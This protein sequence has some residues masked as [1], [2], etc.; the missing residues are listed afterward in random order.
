MVD[1]FYKNSAF[2]PPVRIV[3]VGQV[4]FH[5]SDPYDTMFD[6]AGGALVEGY[7]GT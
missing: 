6:T 2:T 7:N 4:T 5:K 1:Q 3:F